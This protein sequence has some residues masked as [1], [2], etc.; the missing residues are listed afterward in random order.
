ML[1]NQFIIHIGRHK[2]GTSALQHCLHRSADGLEEFG[3]LYPRKCKSEPAHHRIASYFIENLKGRRFS[4]SE[5]LNSVAILKEEVSGFDGPVIL[6]SEAF[7]DCD[8][9]RLTELFPPERTHIVVYLREQFAYAQ[10]AYSQSVH[11]RKQTRTF[12]EFLDQFDPAYDRFLD[13]WQTRFNPDRISVRVY[14]RALLVK[15][16][17]VEDFFSICGLPPELAVRPKRS[18]VNPSIGGALLEFKREINHL[19]IP[20]REL[21]QD[22]YRLLAQVARSDPAL[23]IKPS[24]SEDVVAAFRDRFREA[25]TAVARQFLGHDQLFVAK[26]PPPVHPVSTEQ[27]LAVQEQIRQNSGG[28]LLKLIRRAVIK[29]NGTSSAFLDA[30]R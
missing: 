22:S 19:P 21:A 30:L 7:Q 2:S 12:E 13:R 6:S 15:G 20:Q 14:D 25:N 4:R 8:P 29:H 17:I 23:R 16:D 11:A 9:A 24:A 10:S 3:A 27:I 26:P 5:A 18:D 28:A 1:N